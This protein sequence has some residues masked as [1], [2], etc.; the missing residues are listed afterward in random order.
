MLSVGSVFD[1]LKLNASAF[2]EVT[3]SME[4]TLALNLGAYVGKV[5]HKP[6]TPAGAG[7]ARLIECSSP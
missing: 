2:Y 6:G 5:V 1:M 3:T 7:A 4:R